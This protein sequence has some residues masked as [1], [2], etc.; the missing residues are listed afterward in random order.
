MRTSDLYL[1]AEVAEAESFLEGGA[2]GPF[3]RA[4]AFVFRRAF[5]G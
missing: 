4:A 2:A 3:L 1:P 5:V